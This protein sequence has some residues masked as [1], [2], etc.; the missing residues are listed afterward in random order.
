[1]SLSHH[2]SRGGLTLAAALLLTSCG[3]GSSPSDEPADGADASAD[4]A[5]ASSGPVIEVDE[6]L[7][8]QVPD[9]LK[10]AGVIRMAINPNY[11]PFESMGPDGKTLV[12]LEPDLADAIGDVL[13]LEIEMVPTSF[14]G[15]IPALEAHKVDMAMGSIGDTKEREEVVDFATFYWNGTMIMVPAGNPEGI[16]SEE[17]CGVDI[18]VIRGSLQQS[19]FLPAHGPRC[20]EDGKEPPTAQVY[21]DGPQAQLALKSGRID[22]VML[23]APPLLDAAQKNPED[24]EVVGPLVRNPNPGGVAFPKDSELVEPVNGALNL[25]IES[26]AYEEILTRWNLQDI[27]IEASEING[28]LE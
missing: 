19:T 28:A 4:G 21:Q 1:M 3:L 13:G 11:P 26:G 5:A 20:E 10:E 23:D 2:L 9:D 24:F 18:G 8:A 7:A 12:G 17:A 16:T 15:I 14:D 27:G 22:G 25:L 6:E